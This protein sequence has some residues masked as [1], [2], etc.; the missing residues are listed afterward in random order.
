MPFAGPAHAV[1]VLLA[2]AIVV[3]LPAATAA[4]PGHGYPD[5]PPIGNDEMP[6]DPIPPR[7]EIGG[8]AGL[9]VAF[10]EVG[11]MVSVPTGPGA[12][13][14]VAVGWLPGVVY[15]VEHVVGQMQFRL[16]FR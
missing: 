9:T 11:V 10:P 3:C 14:E 15:N 8:V 12:A 2:A 1:A 4:Q 13:F 5:P 16:P 7:V 6:P